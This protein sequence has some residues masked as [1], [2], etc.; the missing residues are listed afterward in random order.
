MHHTRRSRYDLKYRRNELVAAITGIYVDA[1]CGFKE[2]R[3]GTFLNIDEAGRISLEHEEDF[4]KG[5]H[6][7]DV[8][9]P[10]DVSSDH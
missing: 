8:N 3:R 2:R 4:T 10:S 5:I 6:L 1:H 9:L 7:A